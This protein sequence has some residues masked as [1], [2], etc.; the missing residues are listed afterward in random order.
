VSNVA[1][2][3]VAEANHFE[4]RRVF[5]AFSVSFEKDNLLKKIHT[6][7][8]VGESIQVMPEKARP[9]KSMSGWMMLVWWSVTPCGRSQ[10][11]TP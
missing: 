6:S 8:P 9:L 10:E 7:S 5:I 4:I 11:C 1:K 2:P 3:R